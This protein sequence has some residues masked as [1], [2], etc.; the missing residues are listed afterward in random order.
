M[1]SRMDA[2]RTESGVAGTLSGVGNEPQPTAL[3]IASPAATALLP[4]LPS[5]AQA[6]PDLLDLLRPPLPRLRQN[7][8]LRLH[9]YLLALLVPHR[10]R[11]HD[12]NT[13]L[14]VSRRAWRKGVP[15]RPRLH[16]LPA[17]RRPTR[18]LS[19]APVLSAL[20]ESRGAAPAAAPR[21]SGR[22]TIP[23]PPLGAAARRPA[24]SRAGRVSGH[25]SRRHGAGRRRVVDRIR[26]LANGDS[27][28]GKQDRLGDSDTVD[29][30][31]T[32][33]LQVAQG[34]EAIAE[35]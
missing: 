15:K 34:P 25:R 26:P 28:P 33:A 23:N 4:Q 22:S 7:H 20:L 18:R 6:G 30:D 19:L 9:R 8:R 29:V 32:S 24:D 10:V 13:C 21:A 2:H 5:P 35:D 31:A 27:I 16:R 3:N 11:R 12:S 14:N 1:A 17:Q